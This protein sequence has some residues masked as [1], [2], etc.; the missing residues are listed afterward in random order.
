MVALVGACAL[1]ACTFLS[2]G[3]ASSTS[4]PTSPPPSSTVEAGGGVDEISP[5]VISAVAPD[6]IPVLGSDERVHVAYELTVLNFAPRPAVITSVET[7]APDGEVLTSLSEEEIAARTMIVAD[8]GGAEPFDG[9]GP[10]LRIPAGKTA[11]LV[12][13][14]TYADGDD[15]PTTVTHRISASFGTPESGD[16][17]IAVLWP[18]E[19]TQTGSPV[20]ISTDQPVEISAPLEGQGWLVSNGCC[21][22]DAHRN[23]LL[24][25][26]GRINGAE[27]FALDLEMIDVAATRENGYDPSVEVDGDPTRNEDYLAYGAP[28]LAVADATVVAV[29]ESV[30]DT[31]AGTL[32]LGPGFTLA[33]LGGNSIVLEL[34]TD[35]FAV[36]YHLA[37]DSVTVDVGDHVSEGDEIARLGNSGNSSA[38]HLH[39]QLSRTPLIFSSDAVPYVIDEFTVVGAIDPAGG[40]LLDEPNPGAR[41]DALPLALTIVDFD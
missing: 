37:P 14:D 4:T 8:Y 32:P 23:V 13:D 31:P 5:L 26:G 21:G 33:N 40:E 18:D 38:A 34:A 24:P 3:S 41:R 28:V 11:L 39:F 19:V 9:D 29:E 20:T 36:Y 6:P 12:L 30:P 7:L 22:L 17:G 25:V 35:L 2:A 27:R 10:G 15:V 1:T 16:G